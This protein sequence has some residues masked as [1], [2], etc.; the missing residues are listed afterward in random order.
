VIRRTLGAAVVG[1]CALLVFAGSV[2]DARVAATDAETPQLVVVETVPAIPGVVFSID[3]HQF[4]SDVDGVA[5]TM[6]PRPG[7]YR[8]AVE[9]LPEVTDAR[10]E[11]VRWV[12]GSFERGVEVRLPLSTAVQAGLSVTHRVWPSFVTTDGRPVATPKIDH[13]VVRG[14]TGEIHRGAGG[15]PLWLVAT[16]PV[17]HV[18]GLTATSVNYRIESVQAGGS[19]VVNRGQQQFIPSRGDE[20]QIDVLFF[21]LTIGGRDA[22]FG[23]PLGSAVELKHPDGRITLHQ[24]GEA[25]T[26]TISDLPRG[27]YEAR[28]I[29]AS[30]L[31]PPAPVALSR[32]QQ[33]D[34]VVLSHLNIAVGLGAMITLALGLLLLGRPRILR[35]LL[36]PMHHA[37]VLQVILLGFVSLWV[38]A[39]A[40][41]LTDEIEA[42]RPPVLAYY[43][44][45]FDE[46]SWNR[47]K[48]DYPLLGRYSSDEE[49]VVRRHIRWAKE[50]GIDG[51]IVS[52]KSTLVLDR[53]L[54]QL[55]AIAAEED[56]KLAVIYQGLDFERDPLPIDRI[57]A[58][59]H[60][61]SYRWGDARPFDLLGP[62]PLVIWSGT[63][64]FSAVEVSQV[65]APL[66]S[67]LTIL[68][69]E[70]STSGY[71][72]LSSWVDGN[73]YYWSSVNPATNDAYPE[74]LLQMGEAVRQANGLWIAPAAPG[75]DA[76]Q[77]GGATVV[78][79]VD[80]DTLRLQF[81]AA[82]A[83]SPDAIGIISWNE[84]SENTHV[85]PSFEYGARELDTLS[86]L[87]GG[88]K[89][90]LQD[91]DSSEG[92]SQAPSQT[93]LIAEWLARIMALA[94]P[95][96][97]LVAATLLAV[98]RMR[99]EDARKTVM[100]K[101]QVEES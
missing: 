3:G 62:A 17:R 1:A 24:F 70:R 91:I 23:F 79:R 56:F 45:W 66:R 49:A 55:V 78:D 93:A 22:M 42:Q 87:L 57:T 95:A 47:A 97:G 69:S 63:W 10:I 90:Q 18:H 86:G 74:K 20:W 25:G 8:L 60:Y 11:F 76:R 30:G 6:V 37:V 67:E 14:S 75:F 16:R 68:A 58:D 35:T 89:A 29:G 13:V 39:P 38:A 7:L 46:S 31:A 48:T 82:A 32:S 33:V 5:R 64:E 98:M 71:A 72:R 53:R 43:Y 99:R 21:S 101:R 84:F 92:P 52:W 36:R 4:R 9:S 44:I 40:S 65:T 34:L 26:A 51:F 83:S 27:T 81:E 85:E 61:F 50:A 96:L 12:P 2:S 77:I 73:A 88:R 100:Q 15:D 94:V 54:D 41:A 19:N 28:V 59:L 80:G